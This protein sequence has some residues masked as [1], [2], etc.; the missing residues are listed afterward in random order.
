MNDNLMKAILSM[1]SYN[2]GY[3]AG[4]G[5][6]VTGLGGAGSKIGNLTILNV[7]L[8]T[9]AQAAGFYAVAY[10]TNGDGKGDIISYR[11]TDDTL[12]SDSDIT[13]GWVLGGGDEN[14]TQ[15]NMAI[16][17]YKDVVGSGN[18][19]TANISLTG[20]SL[21]GGLAGYVASLY[22]KNALVYDSMGYITA[23]NDARYY[24]SLPVPVYTTTGQSFKDLIYNGADPWDLNSTGVQGF[25]INGEVLDNR[26]VRSPT[27]KAV[28]FGPDVNSQ[29]GPLEK[30][31]MSTL[32]LG[33]YGNDLS[34]LDWKYAA[35][36]FWAT[37]YNDDYA[38]T[39]GMDSSELSGQMQTDKKY[40]D[41]LRTILAYSAIDE[42]TDNSRPYGSTAISNL[43]EDM[44]AL[45]QA[46]QL[47]TL[48]QNILAYM[49]DISKIAVQ[50]AANLALNDVEWEEL[51]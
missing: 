13:N 27:S 35:S 32:V 48:S 34:Q 33:M 18:L 44:N 36:S 19:R 22:G 39:I 45:G 10:D 5:N 16:Q 11:G 12:G 23:A 20:H 51:S 2:R 26:F 28:D 4:L 31:S 1:D 30:H 40:S 9:G 8:P 50:Y 38:K 3:L 17:F 49:P 25:H 21:G 37:L 46:V 29:F 6:N 15:G 43:Y 7:A 14:A 47:P 42:G 41:I 24:A